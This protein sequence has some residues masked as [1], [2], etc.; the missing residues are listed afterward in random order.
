MNATR[1]NRIFPFGSHLCREPMPPMSE[2]KHDMELLKKQGFNLIKLQEN[3]MID[4][5][6]EGQ[7][8]FSRYEELIAHAASL[9]LG[10]YLGL[11]C[12]QA[13]HWLYEK[14]PDCRMVGRDGR[15]I[16][17]EATSTLPADGKPGPCYDHPGALGDQLRFITRLVQT[18]GRFENVVV[19]NTW[20]EIGYWGEWF[21]GQGVCFCPNT[22]A[23]FRRWLGGQYGDLDA[24]NRAWNTRYPSWSAIQP[25]RASRQPQAVDLAWQTFMDNVQIADVLRR[26]A[27]AIRAA[28]PLKRP[29]FAHK[30]GPAW[31]SGQDWVY[32]RC[33]DFLGSSCYPPWFCMNGWD[34]GGTRPFVRE[35][36]LLAE[37]SAV[38]YA[39]DHIRS[40]NP[41]QGRSG[42]APVWA[43]EFQG[44]PI[45]TGFQ[46]GRVPSPED[47]RRWML[48]AVSSG[49]T[50]ISFWVTRAEIMAAETN[51]FSLLDSV[52]ESTPR[53]EE[54]SRIGRALNAHADLFAQPTMQPAK[55]GIVVNEAN[56]QLCSHLTQGGDNLSYSTRG[57]WRLLWESN[58][59]ADLLS[60]DHDLERLGEYRVVIA[61]FPLSL[62]EAV[63]AK[64]AAYVEAGGCLVSEAAPGRINEEGFCNRGELSPTLATLF[65]VRQTGFQ[66]VREP[67]G[68]ARWSPPER[69]WG[70]YLEAQ[71]LDGTGPLAGQRLRAN[72]YLQTFE[73]LAGADPVLRAGEAVAGVRRRV[74]QGQAWLLGTY[75]GHSGTAYR[76]PAIH[77]AVKALLAACGVVPEHEGKLILRKRVTSDKEAWIFTN[78]TGESITETIE[79]AG[80]QKVNDLLGGAVTVANGSVEVTVAQLDVRVLIVERRLALRKQG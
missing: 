54:A 29:V 38:A 79:L 51:G 20:Q 46:K 40:A 59:P 45:S 42:G 23:S 4:E 16:V 26:R 66:M 28:D 32:A 34:D 10:I 44:G 50:A 1:F 36:A 22:L 30:A 39:I 52:G 11:T 24:L 70:E 25:S 21:V 15:T 27:E 31:A 73:C 14:H 7:C 62:S 17:Y 76:D 9:D 67:D 13:P 49:V 37:V 75:V 69:T 8:D 77:A 57:W 35:T 64:L 56:L 41:G 47:M 48:S 80:W 2:M 19:W 78:P 71:M 3:W 72:V 55:V 68:G 63:A 58:I 53:F 61:P 6:V 74:G 43:A 18:L 60:A 12:E 65:G 33:Q 5:P